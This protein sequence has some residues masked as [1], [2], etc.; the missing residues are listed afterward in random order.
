MVYSLL[1]LLVLLLNAL[2][3]AI[4]FRKLFSEVVSLLLEKHRVRSLTLVVV[5]S[6]PLPPIVVL[7]RCNP[8]GLRYSL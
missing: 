7:Y 5:A 6:Y 1:G 2:Q 4:D 3:L 8:P